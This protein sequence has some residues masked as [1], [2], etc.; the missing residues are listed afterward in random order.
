MVGKTSNSEQ[1]RG[2]MLKVNDSLGKTMKRIASGKK[3]LSGSDDPAG[4][5]VLM[6]MESQTRGITQQINIR[7]D[8]ISMLQTA[9]GAMS[10]INDMLQRMNEL[11]VQASNGTLTDGDREA[12]QF[13]IDQLSEQVNMTANN[14]TYNTKPLLDGSLNVKLQSG[15]NLAINAMNSETLGLTKIDVTSQSG[16]TSAIGQ[17]SSSISSVSSSRGKLGAMQNGISHDIGNLNSQLIS[18]LNAQSRIGDADMAQ[19]IINMSRD[20]LSSSVAIKA[21]R[22]EDESRM[23]VLNLLGD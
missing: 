23:N 1:I 11:S 21:F 16:A 12:I 3:I 2:Q 7:Q 5:A 18:A 6:S 19:E 22:F 17:V 15:D 13:E 10:G 20:Q 14:A 9:E 4:L 8:E